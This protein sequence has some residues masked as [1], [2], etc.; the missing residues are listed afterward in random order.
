MIGK[1]I[2]KVHNLVVRNRPHNENGFY[3]LKVNHLRTTDY[4][5]KYPI[6]KL[7]FAGIIIG[8][9]KKGLWRNWLARFYGIEKVTGSSPV[10][11]TYMRRERPSPREIDPSQIRFGTTYLPHV[12]DEQK[13]GEWIIVEVKPSSQSDPP[14]LSGNFIRY[15]DQGEY[16][17]PTEGGSLT[18]R[19]IREIT[20]RWSMERIITAM[21]RGWRLNYESDP[22]F[23]AELVRNSAR[24][25]EQ[26]QPPTQ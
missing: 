25:A 18:T 15:S 14:L 17:I 21:E 2:G 9:S 10:R 22:S 24:I 4:R 16:I 6:R 19:D 7:H 1:I 3:F 12:V 11:S 20:G 5:K 13:R 23:I 8:L 26:V